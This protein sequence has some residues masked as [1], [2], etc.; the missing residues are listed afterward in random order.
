MTHRGAHCGLPT[1]KQY[2]WDKLA[3]SGFCSSSKSL[4]SLLSSRL[5][6][7]LSSS[8][9]CSFHFCLLP[10]E[11]PTFS[12]LP[13]LFPFRTSVPRGCQACSQVVRAS[14]GFADPHFSKVEEVF[15]GR[16]TSNLVEGAP[17]CTEQ[18]SH[19]CSLRTSIL[20][21]FLLNVPFLL[22]HILRF[23]PSKSCFFIHAK[24]ML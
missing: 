15:L 11:F 23:L 2:F 7:L 16:K 9:L 1:R 4:S 17:P 18:A 3:L 21:C 12:S 6:F 24:G 19:E 10:P 20:L 22:F 14:S 5:A 13:S 8:L